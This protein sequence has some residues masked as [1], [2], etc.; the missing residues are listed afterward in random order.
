MLPV[1][2]LP[3]VDRVLTCW[4]IFQKRGNDARNPTKSSLP[5][6]LL[7]W[8]GIIPLFAAYI[9]ARSLHSALPAPAAAQIYLSYSAQNFPIQF[10]PI[11]Y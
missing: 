6:F 10:P 11:T 5:K 9:S 7:Q 1:T 4:W 3:L 2:K 8:S